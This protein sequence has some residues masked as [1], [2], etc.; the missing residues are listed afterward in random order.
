MTVKEYLRAE[1]P[2]YPWDDSV[3]EK[4]VVSPIFA[5][6]SPMTGLE[7]GMDIIEVGRDPELK[8]ALRY[9]LSTLYYMACGLVSGGNKTE[10]VGNR[11]VSVSGYNI[12]DAERERWRRIADS[13]RTELGCELEHTALN[14]SGM[15]DASMRTSCW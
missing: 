5:K 13:I 3:I 11:R 7:L 14:E 6:P 4:A 15:F 12:T 10:Q 2:G 1:I 8:P 9:S